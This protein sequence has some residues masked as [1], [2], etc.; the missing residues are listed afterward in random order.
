MDVAPSLEVEYFRLSVGNRRPPVA[1]VDLRELMLSR[2]DGL[3][4]ADG[5]ERKVVVHAADR[6]VATVNP[7]VQM[8]RAQ[9]LDR[10]AAP[11]RELNRPFGFIP[12]GVRDR[13]DPVAVNDSWG[14]AL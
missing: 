7:Q 11:Q 6:P 5:L 13:G 10:L 9:S 2:T 8:M 12:H 4:R 1:Q 3:A 14:D